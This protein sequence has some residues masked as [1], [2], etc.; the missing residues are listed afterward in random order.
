[1][2]QPIVCQT[3][4]DMGLSAMENDKKYTN[5]VERRA[6]HRVTCAENVTFQFNEATYKGIM[7]NMSEG[8][9]FIETE[10]R[11]EKGSTIVLNYYSMFCKSNITF[12]G[13]VTRADELGIGVKLHLEATE[14]G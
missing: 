5:S 8:G 9:F 11:P 6:N 3:L 4:T 10:V 2:P 14:I 12:H 1:M 7:Q 13:I